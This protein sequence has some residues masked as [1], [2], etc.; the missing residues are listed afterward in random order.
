[1]LWCPNFSLSTYRYHQKQQI[2]PCYR[3]QLFFAEVQDVQFN[4]TLAVQEKTFQI[5][6][7][8]IPSDSSYFLPK[9]KTFNLIWHWQYKKKHSRYTWKTF[10][11]TARLFWQQNAKCEM[12]QCDRCDPY[13]VFVFVWALNRNSKLVVICKNVDVEWWYIILRTRLKFRILHSPF[14]PFIKKKKKKKKTP[15]LNTPTELPFSEYFWIYSVLLL[16]E[17][18][19]A[20]QNG[21]F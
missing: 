19:D 5:H 9:F 13:F 6:V 16:R 21:S 15:P 14:C 7:K 1:M 8:D 11:P 12:R 17:P 4:L 18:L 10:H 2:L 3:Q 20:L